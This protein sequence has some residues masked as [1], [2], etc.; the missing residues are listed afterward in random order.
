MKREVLAELYCEPIII[1]NNKVL[2]EIF[3]KALDGFDIRERYIEFEPYGL[4]IVAVLG[5][6][7][8]VLH[9][10]P[11]EGRLSVDVYTCG[12][13]APSVVIERLIQSLNPR[14]VKCLSISREGGIEVISDDTFSVNIVP[15]LKAVYNPHKVI[16]S[17]VSKYQKIDIIDHQ[18]FGRMLFLD[19][20]VQLSTSDIEKYNDLMVHGLDVKGSRCV[21]LGG[22]DGFLAKRLFEL[23]AENIKVF[24]IDKEVADLCAEFF[25]TGSN[26]KVEWY[27]QDA[28][29]IT[30]DVVQGTN[31]FLDFTDIPIG[32]EARISLEKLIKK[33]SGALSITAYAGSLL[34]LPQI[35]VVK[36]IIENAGFKVETWSEWMPS[37]LTVSVF[38]RGT[39]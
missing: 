11:E 2:T 4:T 37:Y 20:V 1:G 23:G 27:F 17:K 7:H 16:I 31:V 18:A 28:L 9:T 19:G 8:A 39:K 29:E 35:N 34:D 14:D 26:V 10:F 25:G 3:Y 12:D 36:N 38:V 32:C 33:L 30:E 15:G 21:I 13:I 5:Q 22:G 24:E 6:S